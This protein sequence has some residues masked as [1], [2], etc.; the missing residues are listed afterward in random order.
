VKSHKRGESLFDGV[1]TNFYKR[2]MEC[3]SR[4]RLLVFWVPHIHWRRLHYKVEEIPTDS[5][6]RTCTKMHRAFESLK[7]LSKSEPAFN[8]SGEAVENMSRSTFGSDRPVDSNNNL[9]VSVRI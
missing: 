5:E 3:E 9:G 7:K 2:L 1:T 4:W 8:S 6:I